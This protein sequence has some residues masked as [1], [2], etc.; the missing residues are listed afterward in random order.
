MYKL[1]APAAIQNIKFYG[2]TH[3]RVETLLFDIL[4][5]SM[6][7]SWQKLQISLFVFL[8]YRVKT[9]SNDFLAS[10]VTN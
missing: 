2:G 4:L 9:L 6:R 7:I 5:L 10:A 1:V 3:E 8:Q